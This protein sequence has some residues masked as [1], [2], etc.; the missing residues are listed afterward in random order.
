MLPAR[1]VTPRR[2]MSVECPAM[3]RRGDTRTPER[4][5]QP[6]TLESGSSRGEHGADRTAAHEGRAPEG[7]RRRCKAFVCG[8]RGSTPRS[9]TSGPG[10]RENTETRPLRPD[11]PF[12]FTPKASAPMGGVMDVVQVDADT[13]D[14]CGCRAFVYAE[15]ATGGSLAYCGSHGGRYIP[16][17]TEIGA[18]IVDLRH[19]IH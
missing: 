11:P 4:A 3:T 6:H 1:V 7:L 16:R 10:R 8:H 9:S 19:M 12:P 17:L 5:P 18:T 14:A 15:L 2:G 13:C